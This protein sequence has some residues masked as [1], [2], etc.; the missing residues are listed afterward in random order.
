MR[1]RG[2]REGERGDRTLTSGTAF[3]VQFDK[4]ARRL[5]YNT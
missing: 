5:Q 3:R 1:K 4:D 2:K